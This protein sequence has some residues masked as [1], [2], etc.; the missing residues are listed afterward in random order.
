[1]SQ[2][3]K[4]MNRKECCKDLQD[5]LS[6]LEKYNE[7]QIVELNLANKKLEEAESM[8]SH[9]ISN[10]TNEI[11][12]PFTSIIGLSKSIMSVK[13]EDWKRVITMVAMIVI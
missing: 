2:Q 11:I 3:L 10:V 7:Q 9:F 8:K 12:N 1:M 5:R 13:K 6:K 4:H